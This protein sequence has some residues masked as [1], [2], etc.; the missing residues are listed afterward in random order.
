LLLECDVHWAGVSLG[1]WEDGE[2]ATV[3]DCIGRCGFRFCFG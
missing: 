2:M 1:F 3:K